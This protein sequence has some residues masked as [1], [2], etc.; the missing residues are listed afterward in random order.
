ML[1]TP[2]LLNI[3][4]TFDLPFPRDAGEGARRAEGGTRADR[5]YCTVNVT[6][7]AARRFVRS[8]LSTQMLP[9]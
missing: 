5:A 7:T 9:V 8:L 2:G 1:A 3:A 6:G 4:V